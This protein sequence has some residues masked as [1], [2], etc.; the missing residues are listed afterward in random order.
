V[1]TDTL[2]YTVTDCHGGTDSA[3]IL[4]HLN[5]VSEGS[6]TST[7]PSQVALPSSSPNPFN[8]MTR[9]RFDLP[10][11]GNIELA[12]YDL[13]GHKVKTLLSGYHAAGRFVLDWWG[14]DDQGRRMGSGV[15][16]ARL[17]A[18]GQI[19]VRKMLMIK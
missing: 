10:Q 12:V 18:Q 15:Y 14:V 11:A 5:E 9:I 13:K 8:P 6:S 7:L 4:I 16:F 19:A 3:T 1:S 17:R 2:G